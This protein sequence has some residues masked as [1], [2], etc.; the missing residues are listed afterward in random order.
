MAAEAA[1]VITTVIAA[2]ERAIRIDIEE[3]PNKGIK[4]TSNGNE[5]GKQAN[6]SR[7][8]VTA[9]L[10]EHAPFQHLHTDPVNMP[11]HRI[12]ASNAEKR[13]LDNA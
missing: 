1:W 9:R 10:G 3:T 4:E 13:T 8:S 12:D 6:P 5:M 7:R 11:R 2:A